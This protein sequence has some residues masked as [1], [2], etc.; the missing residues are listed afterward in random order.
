LLLLSVATAKA[1]TLWATRVRLFA[2]A[3]P[4]HHVS[5]ISFCAYCC[6]YHEGSNIY[7]YQTLTIFDIGAKVKKLGA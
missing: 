7:K 2:R 3:R 5:V 4:A 1:Q 6:D